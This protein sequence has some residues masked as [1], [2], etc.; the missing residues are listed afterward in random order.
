[1]EFSDFSYFLH[2]WFYVMA[3]LGKKS[4]CMLFCVSLHNFLPPRLMKISVGN[5]EGNI[6]T[7]W[8]I[9]KI[10]KPAPV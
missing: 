1:M 9:Y 6:F 3:N 5:F 10:W 8:N 2:S 7:Y 4:S